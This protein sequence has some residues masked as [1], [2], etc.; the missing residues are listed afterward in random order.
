M[1]VRPKPGKFAAFSIAY[2]TRVFRAYG[3]TWA[4]LANHRGGKS[5]HVMPVS[6]LE[7]AKV[8]PKVPSPNA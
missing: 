3:S 1:C 8:R 4:C 5:R 7:N 2:V 6:K